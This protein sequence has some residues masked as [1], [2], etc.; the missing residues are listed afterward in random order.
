[1]LPPFDIDYAEGLKVGY[2]WFDAE[3][4]QPLFPFG[5]GLSYTTFRYSGLTASS[6][7][8]QVTVTNT[9]TRAGTAV[10]QLYL[11]LPSAGVDVP[12]P[13]RQLKGYAKVALAPGQSRRVT[14]PLTS[15]SLAYWNQGAQ[16]WKVAAG[17]Y[18]AMVGGSERD[19]EQTG[20][21]GTCPEK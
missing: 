17:C 1:M 19:I 15:R 11:G 8:V 3:K 13:P 12:Q 20:S 7:S 2:K 6:T 16:A 14:F 9:G 18:K 21:F 10:P 5:H 4:K